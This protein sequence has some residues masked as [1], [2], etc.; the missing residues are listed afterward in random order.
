MTK[1]NYN[2]YLYIKGFYYNLVLLYQSDFRMPVLSVEYAA[3][4]A[5]HGILAEEVEFSIPGR[6]LFTSS[7]TK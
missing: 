1:Y 7:F 2:T 3:K 4:K 6:T 5:I